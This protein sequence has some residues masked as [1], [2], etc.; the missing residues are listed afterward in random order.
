[1]SGSGNPQ[2]DDSNSNEASNANKNTFAFNRMQQPQNVVTTSTTEPSKFAFNLQSSSASSSRNAI[3]LFGQT[4]STF[5]EL[6]TNAYKPTMFG[7]TAPDNLSGPPI[8]YR[9]KP[10]AESSRREPP[11]LVSKRASTNPFGGTSTNV[12]G[13]STS[14]SFGG[15]TSNPFGGGTTSN[16]FGGGTISNSFGGTTPNLFGNAQSHQS[17]VFKQTAATTSEQ[18]I[19]QQFKSPPMEAK[20]VIA[21]MKTASVFGGSS[22]PG[23]VPAIFGGH[24][25]TYPPREP[26]VTESLQT[27]FA[28]PKS[29]PKSVFR[30]LDFPAIN[31]AISK[32]EA[33]SALEEGNIKPLLDVEVLKK[34]EMPS[35]R[36]PRI[37]KPH[38]N[39]AKLS[40]GLFG[41]ALAGIHQS[42]PK[43]SKDI[44]K[45]LQRQ[46]TDVKKEGLGSS[47]LELRVKSSEETNKPKSIVC[48]GIAPELMTGD[49]LRKH[50]LKFGEVTKL[51]PN[52]Q[53]RSAVIHFQT[54]KD[55]AN[56]KEFGMHLDPEKEPLSIFWSALTSRKK[57][58]TVKPQTKP[59]K[60]EESSEVNEELRS[61][62]FNTIDLEEEYV[63]KRE[64]KSPVKAKLERMVDSSYR[65]THEQTDLLKNQAKT[66]KEK[67]QI[68]DMRDRLLR[69]NRIKQQNIR[70]ARAIVGTC[71][72]MCPEK[73]RYLREDGGRLPSFE[74]AVTNAGE[75]QEIDHKSAVKEYSRSSADQEEPLPHELRPISVLSMTMDY[76][77]CNVMDSF[78]KAENPTEWYDFVWNRTR[79]IRKDLTQQHLC[80]LNSVA[81]VEKCAR[82][83]IHCAERLCEEDMISF[84]QKINNENL[85]KCL[86]TLKHFY[87]DLAVKNVQCPC[88][89][90]FR[91]YDIILNLNLG[92]ILRQ[93]QQLSLRAQK[94]E[95]VAFAVKVFG[96]LNSNNYVR[97]FKLVR[98]A[99]YLNACLLHR[100]FNQVRNK[101]LHILIR[102]YTAHRPTKFPLPEFTY[103]L[104][105]EN[106]NDASDFC[107]LHGLS[108]GQN[109]IIF[110]KAAF[111]QPDSI[112]VPKRAQT[113]IESKRNRLV[114]E[115]VHSGPLPLN[116]SDTYQPH[117]SFDEN[118]YL[119]TDA[120]LAED[121]ERVSGDSEPAVI[122]ITEASPKEDKEDDDVVIISHQP[123]QPDINLNEMTKDL[124]KDLFIEVTNEM[125]A[126][127]ANESV[128]YLTSLK[129]SLNEVVKT[130]VNEDVGILSRNLAERVIEDR[131]EE[132][133]HLEEIRLLKE[134][135]EREIHS[136]ALL[137]V[138]VDLINETVSVELIND[139]SA[140][141]K[142]LKAEQRESDILQSSR[143]IAT[144]L[145]NEVAEE[146]IRNVSAMVYEEDV[147]SIR[148]R[149][150]AIAGRIRLLQARHYVHHWRRVVIKRKRQRRNL[151]V[152]PCLPGLLAHKMSAS[153]QLGGRNTT[154]PMERLEA[155]RKLLRLMD[156][157]YC[158]RLLDD[159]LKLLPLDICSLVAPILLARSDAVEVSKYSKHFYWKLV[160]SLPRANVLEEGYEISE[161][162][163]SKLS[164]SQFP[165]KSEKHIETINVSVM[166]TSEKNTQNSY[167]FRVYVKRILGTVNNSELRDAAN[168]KLLQATNA[169]LFA[170]YSSEKT[171]QEFW[172]EQQKRLEQVISLR[173]GNP[174]PVFAIV[175]FSSRREVLPESVIADSMNLK[176][177]LRGEKYLIFRCDN[178]NQSVISTELDA[179]IVS[180]ARNT[181]YAKGF[182]GQS[183]IDFLER[184]LNKYFSEPVYRNLSI[185]MSMG[186]VHQPANVLISLFNCVVSHAAKVISSDSLNNLSWPPHE[187][188]SNENSTDILSLNWND[189]SNRLRLFQ[190]LNQL[191]L[192]DFECDG[193]NENW[194]NVKESILD[195]ISGIVNEKTGDLGLRSKIEKLLHE[196]EKQHERDCCVKF[197]IAGCE[198]TLEN[199][200]W[201]EIVL[202]ILEY[203]LT[204]IINEEEVVYYFEDELAALIFPLSW[205][206]AI[207]NNKNTVSQIR[208]TNLHTSALKRKSE[209]SSINSSNSRKR[210]HTISVVQE[211]QSKRNFDEVHRFLSRVEAEKEESKRQEQ[212]LQEIILGS[213]F[214]VETS[215]PMISRRHKPVR[216][217]RYRTQSEVPVRQRSYRRT[218]SD[219]SDKLEQLRMEL[220]SEKRGTR[221]FDMRFQMVFPNVE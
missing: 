1:M 162:L 113:L 4:P 30:D 44:K 192:P 99:T 36:D 133:K 216:Y 136:R 86:Q 138:G 40:A 126:E 173:S 22:A 127:I 181:N 187:F 157:S 96:A 62:A 161:W 215:T 25:L 95:P 48:H 70:T 130:I 134:K 148:E 149:L 198:P 6:N 183:L 196:S 24:N 56:A 154:L 207:V 58:T 218:N 73:E 167:N 116:P 213:T 31:E 195:Y 19:F 151:K 67:F 23:T 60:M 208:H 201:T 145:A 50:F 111:D 55:A 200:P 32:F 63:G 79:S 110:D 15:K 10:K 135:E 205:K 137:E 146:Q 88:E 119:R 92:D 214:P 54:H 2:G 164:S 115:I 43:S 217:A 177:I 158:S 143:Q 156:V 104:G 123:A 117:S 142:E 26:P 107:V 188:V 45:R 139:V 120:I 182:R 57:R 27:A 72:D 185:R 68:L 97:F 38:L 89:D 51:Y 212:Q 197:R 210:H 18:S 83:H 124:A 34:S 175:V 194:D 176:T 186:Y 78:E 112:A 131:F 178:L 141:I 85:T 128:D 39:R 105:F 61:M 37:K 65:F 152:F 121:Q 174:R 106:D 109:E 11:K 184:V 9:N 75:S 168:E 199:I 103:V 59:T 20:S 155:Q 80:D 140:V 46:E 81:L 160:L 53:K 82:F 172:I 171:N 94:S 159:G 12:F 166:E 206:R 41:Q 150:R 170:V 132:V 16:P 7:N 52:H 221:L 144:D 125:I 42:K 17:N 21:P 90:E 64:R 13:G 84:D 47:N 87:H 147:V 77:V 165:N 76:L 93:V 14:K 129:R 98:R 189:E 180:L 114:G 108:V 8:Q 220:E 122:D 66:A 33:R 69:T 74:M 71:P 193:D 35:D 211:T 100:Y 179:C 219:L 3:P 204:S 191:I 101:A 202:S 163:T 190:T 102:A 169:V 209:I 91:G 28:E 5:A 118:G 49:F 153:R 203:R 29:R